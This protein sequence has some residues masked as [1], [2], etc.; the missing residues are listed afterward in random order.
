MVPNG[1]FES[2]DISKWEI[3]SWAGQKLSVVEDTTTG[4][5]PITTQRTPLDA[6]GYYTLDGRRLNGQP[7]QRGLYIVNGKK[8]LIGK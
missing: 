4:I 2:D 8:M 1:T 5:A 7:T 3:I 6:Q